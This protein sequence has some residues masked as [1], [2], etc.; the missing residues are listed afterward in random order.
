MRHPNLST[1]TTEAS[2][3]VAIRDRDLGPKT[4]AAAAPNDRTL[5]S[6]TPD[7]NRF[8]SIKYPLDLRFPFIFSIERYCGS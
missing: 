4:E 8:D 5:A 7:K 6:K 1:V 2:A 3:D